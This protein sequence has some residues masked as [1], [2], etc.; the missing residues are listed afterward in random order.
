MKVTLD[1]VGF[2]YCFNGKE[3]QQELQTNYGTA[4]PVTTTTTTTTPSIQQIQNDWLIKGENGEYL[5][6]INLQ[7]ELEV[8]GAFADT[9]IK[10]PHH[11]V[12]IAVN[13]R[14][15]KAIQ[16]AS[17]FSVGTDDEKGRYGS[18]LTQDRIPP[19]LA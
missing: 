9:K 11:S 17:S 16:G 19:T 6:V 1:E 3:W 18:G 4:H 7:E 15:I 14:V 13:I 8:K 12:V 2:N 5:K 10:I